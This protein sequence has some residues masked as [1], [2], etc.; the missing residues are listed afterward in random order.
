MLHIA[1]VHWE[2]DK[3]IDIQ[4]HYIEKNIQQ[5]YRIYTFLSGEATKHRHK[6]Y[7][8]SCEPIK[9]HATKLNILADIICLQAQPDDVVM[10]IDGDAFPIAPIDSYIAN[11]LAQHPLAAI[12]RIENFGECQPHPSFCITKVRY[13][14]AIGGDW[15]KGH[16]WMGVNNIE[17]TDVGGNLLKILQD[18]QQEWGKI[19]R[20]GQL[21]LHGLLFGIYGGVIYHHGAGFRYEITHYDYY[22]NCTTLRKI[23]IPFKLKNIEHYTAINTQLN[24]FLLRVR[25]YKAATRANR[26]TSMLI[27]NKI[28]NKQIEFK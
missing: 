24:A 17:R 28:M 14:R 9:S 23:I 22:S 15:N 13:W 4:L 10:F 25:A 7:F 16:K 18:R 3:W 12:Q 27:Y 11:A 6:F 21:S 1:T 20:T 2:T 19:H 8:A 26:R 5:P